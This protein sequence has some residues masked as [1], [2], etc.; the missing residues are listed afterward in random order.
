MAKSFKLFFS[1][2]LIFSVVSCISVPDVYD[3]AG[4]LQADSDN[5]SDVYYDDS[6]D[7]QSDENSD[8]SD[9]LT[10]E[11]YRSVF[12]VFYPQILFIGGYYTSDEKFE[13]SQGQVWN[14]K[15]V[16]EDGN[17]DNIVVERARLKKLDDGGVWWYFSYSMDEETYDFEI[18]LDSGMYIR[19]I[20][21]YDLYSDSIEEL[22]YDDVPST[23]PADYLLS[24]GYSSDEEFYKAVSASVTRESLELKS[25]RWDCRR[26]KWSYVDYDGAYNFSWWVDKDSDWL[27]KFSWSNTDTGDLYEGELVSIKTGYTTKFDSY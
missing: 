10:S 26:I 20:R 11:D 6:H 13:D 3:A 9:Y 21:Y 17:V 16:D 1:V 22:S 8:S 15:S 23:D 2:L 12:A 27:V 5:N 18:L 25:G 4:F 14:I 7:V 19:K 24:Y